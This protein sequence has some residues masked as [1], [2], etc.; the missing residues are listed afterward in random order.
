MM[1]LGLGLAAACL[2]IT[3]ASGAEPLDWDACSVRPGQ[4]TVILPSW[5]TADIEHEDRKARLRRLAAM[6]GL[7]VAP[8]FS[9]YVMPRAE[10][11]RVA[12]DFPADVPIL[13]VVF[14][15]RLLF[16]VDRAELRPEALEILGVIAE[17]LR[18]DTPDVALFVAGHTDATASDAYNFNLSLRRADT[19]AQA[20]RRQGVGL[21]SIFRVGFGEAVPVASNGA[22]DGRRLNRRVEFIFAARPEAAAGWLAR[23]AV[24][25]CYAAD[26]AALAKCRKTVAVAEEVVGSIDLPVTPR[27][28]SAGVGGQSQAARIAARPTT[29]K[30]PAPRRYT[31][32]LGKRAVA[33]EMPRR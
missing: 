33:I 5:C 25:T 24:D 26:A 13:R 32:D 4:G 31:L 15:E 3:S 22:E 6:Q 16:A 8:A 21:A 7:G 27:K 14:P 11:A 23:Q 17:A 18:R 2:A 20:L 12:P 19:V 10:L 30:P 9:E 29:I 28:Q 1:R